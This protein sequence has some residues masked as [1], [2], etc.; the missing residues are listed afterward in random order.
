MSRYQTTIRSPIEIT[1]EGMR[2]AQKARLHMLP[3][4]GDTGILWRRVD[5]S[6]SPSILSTPKNLT[7]NPVGRC[8]A[9]GRDG[10]V[11]Y[12]V[13]H[14]L[15]AL[16]GLGVDNCILELEGEEPPFG[17]G[18][19]QSLVREILRVGIKK[20][21]EKKNA[22]TLSDSFFAKEGGSFI[23]ASPSSVFAISC[24]F[25][26]DHRLPYLNHQFLT[27]TLDHKTFIPEIAPARTFIYDWETDDLL[28]RGW[29]KY[30][31]GKALILSCRYRSDFR[32]E[33]EPVRHK[34]L[35]L[36]GD[37]SL[38]GP[39]NMHVVAYRPNHRLNG[40][41]VKYVADIKGAIIPLEKLDDT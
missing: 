2:T 20:L 30:D 38:L 12:T 18:S 23:S 11:V 19:A 1:G 22:Y 37:L 35:D 4:P 10:V 6:G 9:L 13:E 39:V 8:T 15:A 28:K 24:V 14:V 16:K 27:Y 33:K 26:N 34:I 5:L 40:Q 7:T 36:I 3:A 41:L 32:M 31:I 17:D 29:E 21:S 25:T